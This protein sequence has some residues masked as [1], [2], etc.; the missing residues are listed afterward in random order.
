[1]IFT[2]IL[3]PAKQVDRKGYS[4]CYFLHYYFFLTWFNALEFLEKRKAIPFKPQRLSFTEVLPFIKPQMRVANSSYFKRNILGSICGF[5]PQ[6]YNNFIKN[7]IFVPESRFGCCPLG[8]GYPESRFQ[9]LIKIGSDGWARLSP[10]TPED[11][12]VFFLFLT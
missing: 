12:P 8:R 1:M 11:E 4:S 10:R 5:L 2:N 3:A 9:I 6:S 7:N